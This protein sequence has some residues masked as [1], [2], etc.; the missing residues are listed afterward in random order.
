MADMEQA[1]VT[2]SDDPAVIFL[3]PMCCVDPDG[4]GGRQWCEDAVWECEEGATPT[5]Y[6]RADEADRLAEALRMIA[7]VDQGCGGTLTYKEMAESAMRQARE[8]LAEWDTVK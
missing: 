2:Q 6:V 7:I 3:Q 5:K 1:E 8:A 4:W